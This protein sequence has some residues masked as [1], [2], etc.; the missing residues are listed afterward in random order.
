MGKRQG[1]HG[2]IYIIQ[3][4]IFHYIKFIIFLKKFQII[5]KF[6]EFY[7]SDETNERLECLC[8]CPLFLKFA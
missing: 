4:I 1:L 5:L 6:A 3:K 2:L 8:S 7:F